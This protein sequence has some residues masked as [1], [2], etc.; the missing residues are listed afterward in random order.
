MGESF[1][2]SSRLRKPREFQVVEAQ[3]RVTADDVL[4]VKAICNE[5][6][7]TRL[8]ISVNKRFG[9]AVVRNR[10]K[11]IIRDAFRRMYQQLP[12]GLDLVVKPRRGAT[13]DSH[14]VT[15]SLIKLAKAMSRRFNLPP[16]SGQS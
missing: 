12:Q 7:F 15:A 10:W 4:V 13:L 14:Q 6:G 8:G 11:R 5:L 9:G 3:G 16:G 2:K 1:P